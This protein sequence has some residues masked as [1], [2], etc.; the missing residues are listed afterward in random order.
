[1]FFRKIKG[2]TNES[3][4]TTSKTPSLEAVGRAVWEEK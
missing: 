4:R 3:T 2:K 1:M